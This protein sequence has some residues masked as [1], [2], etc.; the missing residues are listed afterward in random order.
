MW[1]VL[2]NSLSNLGL[3]KQNSLPLYSPDKLRDISSALEQID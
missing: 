1:G 2:D 3:V